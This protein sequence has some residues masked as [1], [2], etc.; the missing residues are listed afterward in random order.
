MEPLDSLYKY[1]ARIL[2][3]VDGD[4]VK[5]DVDLG[6]GVF[7]RTTLRLHHIDAPEVRGADKKKG[8]AATA[9]LVKLLMRY[10]TNVE[11]GTLKG[12][13][14]VIYIETYKDRTGKY[15]RYLA[16][17]WGVDSDGSMVNINE[18]MISDGHA[19][20]RLMN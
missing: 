8:K 3:V 13:T 9:H 1:K 19:V 5:A 7:K 11:S 15:G 18:Q 20:E 6:L 16:E 12:N 10:A 17:L 2:R 14:S 4:T